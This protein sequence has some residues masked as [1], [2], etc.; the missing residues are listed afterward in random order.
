MYSF[1]YLLSNLAYLISYVYSCEYLHHW[2]YDHITWGKKCK[3]LWCCFVDFKKAFDT[4]SRE[5]LGEVGRSEGFGRME[6]SDT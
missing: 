5:S 1:D 6:V 2:Y 4:V 3:D